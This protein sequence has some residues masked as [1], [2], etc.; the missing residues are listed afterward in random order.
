[1]RNFRLR[2]DLSFFIKKKVIIVPLNDDLVNN[3]VFS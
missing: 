1:M 2:E 3:D